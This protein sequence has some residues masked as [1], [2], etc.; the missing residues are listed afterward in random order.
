MQGPTLLGARAALIGICPRGWHS[1]P[2]SGSGAM[3]LRNG[4][5]TERRGQTCRAD[6]VKRTIVGAETRSKSG[7]VT[8]P[9]HARP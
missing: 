4:N 7:L 9:P 6:A 5:R 8:S 3:G 1:T 2:F